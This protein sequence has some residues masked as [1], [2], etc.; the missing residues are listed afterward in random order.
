MHVVLL[1]SMQEMAHGTHKRMSHAGHGAWS[2]QKTFYQHQTV[3]FFYISVH[4]FYVVIVSQLP[5]LKY[6]Q[7]RASLYFGL[8]GGTL[9]ILYYTLRFSVPRVQYIPLDQSPTSS[10]QEF[11]QKFGFKHCKYCDMDVPGWDHH[12]AIIG[13]SF[14]LA[15]KS[16]LPNEFPIAGYASKGIGPS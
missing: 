12:C 4:I 5:A 2:S 7:K 15:Q 3:H 10:L 6:N 9:L 8:C 14:S 11:E 1:L 16:L 13:I